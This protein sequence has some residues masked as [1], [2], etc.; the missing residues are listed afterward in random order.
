MT[1]QIISA[2]TCLCHHK[3]MMMLKTRIMAWIMKMAI[4]GGGW[5]LTSSGVAS[6]TAPGGV[7]DLVVYVSFPGQVEGQREGVLVSIHGPI[8]GLRVGVQEPHPFQ[9]IRMPKPATQRQHQRK[10]C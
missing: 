9:D 3:G 5:Q 1:S 10:A 4:V 8:D 7:G 2:D 6:S